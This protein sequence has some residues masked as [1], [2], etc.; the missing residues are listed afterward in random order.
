M[1]Y[2]RLVEGRYPDYRRVIPQKHTLKVP[3]TVGTFHAAV[4]QAAIMTDDESKKVV[5]SLSKR[6][7]TLQAQSSVTG[8]SRVELAVDYEGK[9]LE[10]GLDPKHLKDMLSVLDPDAPL[11]LELEASDKPALLHTEANDFQYVAM[12]MGL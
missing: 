10:I 6:K 5:F 2:G 3:L 12:P 9:P 8:R 4:R 7:L 11:L 1:I